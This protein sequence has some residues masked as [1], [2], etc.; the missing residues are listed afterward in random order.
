MKKIC[1]FFNIIILLTICGCKSFY[2][3]QAIKAQD[4]NFEIKLPKLEPIFE[5]ET[6]VK[7]W[8]P[9]E[10][11][12]RENSP[13]ATLFY[14][15]IEKNLV[16]PYG[17]SEGYIVLR[18]IIHSIEIS[19]WGYYWLSACTAFSINLLGV[20]NN[21]YTS[22]TELEAEILNIKGELIKKYSAE[23]SST[24]YVALWWGYD[25][26]SGANAAMY[27]SYTKALSSI[28]NQI[29]EDKEY[30]KNKLSQ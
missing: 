10:K 24:E 4:R 5:N 22:I 21:S 28:I 7:Y 29:N 25:F 13:W 15:E 9:G 18:P 11:I 17:T 30:L 3:N 26:H 14:R 2:V 27:A 1:I 19:G 16:N 6:E 23:Q 12:V 20:P 8:K